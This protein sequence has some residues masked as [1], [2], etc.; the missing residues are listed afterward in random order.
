MASGIYAH[1]K[2]YIAKG[3]VNLTVDTIRALLYDTTS[4]IGTANPRGVVSSANKGFADSG[5]DG[6]GDFT[7]L[8]E[9]QP[10]GSS[11]S[12]TRVTLNVERVY[13][14]ANAR[15]LFKVTDG[16]GTGQAISFGSL[17]A[18]T[19]PAKGVLLFHRSAKATATFT[20]GN[21]EFDDTNDATITLVDYAGKS[22]VYKIK[23]DYSAA[24]TA[25]DREFNA[26]GSA[27]AAAANFKIAVEHADNHNGTIVVTDGGSGAITMTQA[28][29]GRAGNTVITNSN[30][31][32]ICDV[33]VEANFSGGGADGGSDSAATDIPL[34]VHELPSSVNGNGTT[35]QVLLTD[36]DAALIL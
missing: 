27:A 19:N 13:D 30:W 7:T 34:I 18:G 29:P 1:A 26:G 16:S 33:N 22:L 15:V 35:F 25:S 9:Y 8:G 5:V 21:T 2:D 17:A 31:D 3:N 11:S 36:N 6:L 23:N 20:L 24:G 28:L 12:S 32:S 4:T 14:D 10:G